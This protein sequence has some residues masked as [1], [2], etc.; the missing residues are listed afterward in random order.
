VTCVGAFDARHSFRHIVYG[1]FRVDHDR[2]QPGVSE[3]TGRTTQVMRIG[4]DLVPLR[5]GRHFV[6][7]SEKL[8]IVALQEGLQLAHSAVIAILQL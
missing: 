1:G 7:D 3:Q 2:L 8:A 6:G 5:R 4:P